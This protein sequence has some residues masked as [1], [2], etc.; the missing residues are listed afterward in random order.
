VSLERRDRITKDSESSA[1]W[2]LSGCIGAQEDRTAGSS[3]RRYFSRR[4]LRYCA[5]RQ[6]RRELF[7]FWKLEEESTEGS[8]QGC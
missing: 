7:E 8:S 6:R 2:A 5:D 1:R 3:R 4:A